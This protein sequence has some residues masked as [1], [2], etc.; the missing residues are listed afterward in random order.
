MINALIVGSFMLTFLMLFQPQLYKDNDCR[1]GQPEKSC[2]VDDSSEK[3]THESV[4]V[5]RPG[6]HM[7][8]GIFKTHPPNS[9]FS[10][11]NDSGAEKLLANTKEVLIFKERFSSSTLCFSTADIQE[12]AWCSGQTTEKV[13]R[14]MGY[15]EKELVEARGF[16]GGIWV[17]W[18]H[19]IKVTC[20]QKHD[21]FIQLEIEN[22]DGEKWGD[23]NEIADETEQRGGSPPN[24][25]RCQN[26]RDWINDCNLIDMHTA[27]PFYTWEGPKRPRQEKLYKRLDRILCSTEWRTSLPDATAKCLMKLHSDHHPL[28]LTTEEQ[29][30]N[31]SERP[32]R[33]EA[34][35]L[36]HKEFG[37]FL[38]DK[39]EKDAGRSQEI[40]RYLGAD[41]KHGRQTRRNF[42]HIIENI[43]AKLAGWKAKCLSL[44][45]R[46]TLIQSVISSMPYYH[47]Q[48][49]KLP[50]GITNQIEKIE[51][52]FLWG[53]TTEKRSLHQIKWER[54]CLP[55]N[56]GGLGFRKMESM[57]KAFIYKL[58]WNL[59]SKKNDLCSEILKRKYQIEKHPSAK[60]SSKPSDSRLWKEVVRVWPDFYKNIVWNAGN[61]IDIKF[62]EDIWIQGVP[63]L[64]SQMENSN[65][66]INKEST[67]L[68][69]VDMN[70]QWML[71]NLKGILPEG[72]IAQIRRSRTPD[73]KLGPDMPEWLPDQNGRFSVK[74]AYNSIE[75]ITRGE[76]TVWDRIWK[77]KTQERNKYLLWRLG[78]GKLPTRSRIAAW[79]NTSSR[80]PRCNVS[81]ETNVHIIRDCPKSVAIWNAF[82]NPRER[83]MFFSLPIKDWLCWNLERKT[84]F[85]GIPWS[86][87]FSVACHNIWTWRNLLN[88]SSEGSWPKEP[89]R[90]IL[91]Q[92]R[93]M[94]HALRVSEEKRDSKH[95]GVEKDWRK[96]D[97]PW[98]KVNTDGAVCS[99]NGQA[100]CG[101]IF[102]DH[103]GRWLAGFM[104]NI[105]HSTVLSAEL[106]GIM[107]SL[108]EAWERGYRKVELECDSSMAIKGVLET[109]CST[110]MSHPTLFNIKAMLEKEWE[111]RI[112][113]IP[114][115][116]NNCADR[117][118]K[119]SLS[120]PSGILSLETM[121]E[122]IR[123]EVEKDMGLASDFVDS[124]G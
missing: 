26:F 32:F 74:S 110:N 41:I 35:W 49:S 37:M 64:S 91:H 79:S 7:Q 47:M 55:K 93:Q 82:I 4:K 29:E 23:L 103:K 118:A 11:F 18:N 101:G 34:C 98:I 107:Y 39:W 63:K 104:A 9:R 114:R 102:R 25:Q 50:K 31:P 3:V 22:E 88:K 2:W 97:A 108:R 77:T 30:T 115:S 86:N 10:L 87:V 27:G 12:L 68:D 113:P 60:L 28:L 52:S 120:Y 21:Q 73:Y 71:D 92:A 119:M 42:K 45:G 123:K 48:H 5:L 43:G 19:N 122:W 24:V 95:I 8:L 17:V 105:G 58:A 44:A 20:I 46:A 16:S 96:P 109:D 94:H 76:K 59:V 117:L 51:R 89:Y 56:G 80:C 72:T 1:T 90:I 69:H 40:G 61:G 15:P 53:S 99:R 70:G 83:A 14:N 6:K 85:S 124:G 67:L 121:P 66:P 81:R 112:K 78:H 100:G 116:M 38:K 13:I 33:F 84:Q 106:W 57:N 54:T 111:V 75:G 65:I 36:Q 62:W